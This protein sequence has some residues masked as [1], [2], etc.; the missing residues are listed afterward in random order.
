MPE[1]T[2]Y[3]LMCP[4]YGFFDRF[5]TETEAKS[6]AARLMTSRNAKWCLVYRVQPLGSEKLVLV[7]WIKRRCG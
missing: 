2:G 7:Q 3:A 5:C 4:A 1:E 6:E